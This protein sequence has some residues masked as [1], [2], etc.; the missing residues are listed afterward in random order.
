MDSDPAARVASLGLSAATLEA[1]RWK[2]A[3]AWLGLT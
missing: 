3:A 1:L 2:N